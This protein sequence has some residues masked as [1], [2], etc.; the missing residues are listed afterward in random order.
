MSVACLFNKTFVKKI[1]V[2]S[3]LVPS[4]AT[5]E[6]WSW[7]QYLKEW[8]AVAAPVELF[9]KD[10]SFPEHENGF[11][12]GMRL[13]GIDPRRPS[14][15]CVLS[16]A[17]VCGY[18]LRLHFD[19]YLSC[20][21]FWTNAG[22]PDIHPVGWCEKTK[23]ELHIPRGYRKDKFVWMD[24][25]K[26]CKL[27]NAP[28]K[29]FRNRSCNGL[30]PK[31]FQVGMKLE[32]VDRK[33][34]SLVC[35]ATIAD[36]VE[37]R[38]RVHFDNWD[39]S[40]DYWCDVNSPYVQPIG[41]CQ[42]NGRTLIAPQGYPNPKKF[43]WKHY[44]EA[45]Q[46]NAVPAEV[47]NMRAPHGFL[48]NMKLE[49]VD[50]RNPQLIRV[51]TIIDVDDQRV[52]VHFDGWDH[53]YDYWMDADS[54]D[55]HP[56]GWC[57]VTGHP[58]E[59]PYGAKDMKTL[60]GQAVCPTPGC[61]GKGHIRGPRYA[62]HHSAFGCPYSDMNLK[63]E[64]ALQDRLREQTQTNL[65]SDSSH[66]KSGNFCNLNF[67]G[68]YEKV[69]SQPRLVQQA[70]CL[71]IKGKEDTD[72]DNLFREYSAERVQQVLHQS[73]FMTSLSAHPFRDLPLGREQHCKLLPGVADI[74][75]N[76]VTQWTVDEV[77]DFV[78]SLLGCEEHAKCFKKEQIDG[79]A[80]LLLTQADIVKVM[81]I[82]LGPAL[83]IYNSI[84]MFR[85]SQD[86]TEDDVDPG[87]EARG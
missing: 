7:E 54:P 2:F 75:A 20:Y 12:I 64:A 11:Q 9:S 51:A 86:L 1:L 35:V 25:L 10:Q 59:V 46:T 49:A 79:K 80:F 69:N 77:A 58:L 73:I 15:F 81:K 29:L 72:L 34:P 27:Q 56:I 13:E 38:L 52:K 68:K 61:R 32:A 82:K 71:K 3:L 23:H 85:N 21:D 24:Y 8:N 66:T 76:Q 37:D 6:T 26:A 39:D 33:N 84:L 22:S 14:V 57:D 5:Q 62:G 19:G 17:E 60:P 31:E 83:K 36:I 50:K 28:K 16:V 67:S 65:E 70:K 44:L 55:I 4:V 30:V 18:R 45:T 43:S 63:R 40:Y 87:Q 74:Q 41:W 53:K 78:Q 48:P 47:L 42:E